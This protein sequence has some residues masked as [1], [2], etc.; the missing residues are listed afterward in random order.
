ME[1]KEKIEGHLKRRVMLLEDCITPFT[2]QHFITNK[3]MLPTWGDSE[4][5]AMG[6]SVKTIQSRVDGLDSSLVGIRH[7]VATNGDTEARPNGDGLNFVFAT[8][9]LF[10]IVD[11]IPY[12]VRNAADSGSL[13]GFVAL[14]AFDRYLTD[15]I[16]RLDKVKE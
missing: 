13:R 11:D 5:Y 16:K 14:A 7:M 3:E 8:L 15:Q 10:A 1:T 6:C 2:Y 9:A 12:S 4:K